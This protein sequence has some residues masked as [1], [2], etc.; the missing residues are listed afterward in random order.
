MR[1]RICIR[2]RIRIHPTSLAIENED[3]CAGAA[4]SLVDASEWRPRRFSSMMPELSRDGK[5]MALRGGYA[6]KRIYRLDGDLQ[7][8]RLTIVESSATIFMATVQGAPSQ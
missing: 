5:L 8:V 2:I 1:M 6:Q 3:W 7:S 4:I